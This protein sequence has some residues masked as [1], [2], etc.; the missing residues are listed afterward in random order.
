MTVMH[1]DLQTLVDAGS[2]PGAAARALDRLPSGTYVQHK[3]W[4]FGRVAAWNLP[5]NQVL[6]D[7]GPKK[8]HP[9]QLAYAAETLHPLSA[10]H[11]LVR[12]VEDLPG[13]KRLAQENPGALVAMILA[14]APNRRSTP[15]A[16]LALLVPD[17]FSEP[18]SRR[19]WDK[20]KVG[21]KRDG[22]FTV[23]VKKTDPLEMRADAPV[24]ATG[25][26]DTG[27]PAER[28]TRRFANARQTKDQLAALDAMLGE[29]EALRADAVTVLVPVVA[30][31]GTA[32]AQGSRLNPTGAIE[33][34]VARDELAAAAGLALPEGAPTLGA[35]LR[36]EEP[37]L[38]A[39]LD[40]LPAARQRA[41]IAGLPTAFGE[42][43]GGGGGWTARAFALL[44]QT[45][46][47]RVV[48]EV[49]K[50]F[51]AASRAPEL[52]RFFDRSL[53]D[54]SVSCEML[55]WLLREHRDPPADD[56]FGPLFGPGLFRAILAALDRDRLGDVKRGTRLRD[57]FLTDRTL[58]ASLLESDDPGERRSAARAL[59]ASP[60]LDELDKRSL[61]ARLM[62]AHPDLG[63][64]LGG[65]DGSSPGGTA[66]KK[67]EAGA[68]L[69]VSWDSLEKRKAEYDHLVNKE[70]PKNSQEIGLARSYGDLRENFEFKAAKEM[71]TV[72]MRRKA[73]ME[74]ALA[75]AR[76]TNFENPDLSQ[77]SIGTIVTLRETGGVE[78]AETYSILGAW[79][80][81]PTKQI[82]SYQTA[83]GQ[84][85]LGHRTGDTVRLPGDTPSASAREVVIQEIKAY[86]P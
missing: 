35:L 36:A 22:R 32:A 50:L 62:K 74:Q 48:G 86:A 67:V 14:H 51:D 66:E 8:N 30:A 72:L 45:R 79:D 31:A 37:R 28:L 80:G 41:A 49:A 9:M 44:P 84:A 54:Y 73:E 4:G 63:N 11:F 27:N 78:A 64:L 75:R 16:L 65:G 12:K 40:A 83:M 1:P 5:G 57:L 19:W 17:V 25:A 82:I 2:L 24:G 7:F 76:G 70:I 13:I 33:L 18:E 15:A 42:E 43:D 56:P 39:T 10:D 20:V 77:V 47:A 34:L 71:Q 58:A 21:L 52:A 69:I 68:P 81:D 53:R 85:L 55:L 61:M 46:H 38:A 59:L 3:S 29:I 23:P 6:V 26:A 60:I